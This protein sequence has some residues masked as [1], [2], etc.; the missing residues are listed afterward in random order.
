MPG[1]W[2][3]LPAQWELEDVQ[4]VLNVIITALST[5]IIFIFAR[6][7]WSRAAKRVESTSEVPLY[8]LVSLSSLGEVLDVIFLLKKR[9]VCL[10]YSALCAQCLVIGLFSATALLSG[11]I[12]RYST[13]RGSIVREQGVPGFL[14]SRSHNGMGYAN[15][16]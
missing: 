2:I 8:T 5:L 10:R 9:L 1:S 14:A 15:V 13:R 7:C 12:A 11:P 6:Y 16:E 3:S 4:A